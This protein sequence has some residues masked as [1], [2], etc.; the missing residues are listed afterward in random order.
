MATVQAATNSGATT[1]RITV[2]K[3]WA[4]DSEAVR[5]E[6]TEIHLKKVSATLKTGLEVAIAMK[7]LAGNSGASDYASPNTTIYAFKKAEK[8]KYDEAVAR[9]A[10][11]ENVAESGL[12]VYMWFDNGTIYYYSEADNIYMNSNSAH[13]FRGMRNLADIDGVSAL[14][15][16]YVEV[17]GGMFANDTSLVN[18]SPLANWDTGNVKGM[19]YMFGT[20]RSGSD[21]DDEKNYMSYTDLSPLANWNTQSV[22]DMFCIF[23]NARRITTLAPIGG[24]NVSN[25]V[26]AEQMFNRTT[27]LE[28]ASAIE[29]WDLRRVGNEYQKMG[30]SP[31]MDGE[32]EV[33]RFLGMFRLSGV[34]ENGNLPN[35]TSRSGTW[36]SDGALTPDD[37]PLAGSVPVVTKT[38]DAVEEFTIGGSGVKWAKNGDTWM[39][40]V[41][42]SN[43]GSIWRAWEKTENGLVSAKGGKGAYVESSAGREGYGKDE[44][45]AVKVSSGAVEFVNTYSAKAATVVKN[46]KTA[47]ENYATVFM[48]IGGAVAGLGAMIGVRRRV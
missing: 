8:A 25:L 43:D 12:A 31:T 34:L 19:R 37:A 22:V 10:T 11:M 36:D 27:S 9:G 39:A 32:I 3:K 17:M 47:G 35:F 5:S 4:G 18:L 28:D 45:N 23:K 44:A 29:G 26:M 48:V 14:N 16:T 40:S 33:G 30:S 41:E 21:L 20:V 24:W 38:K 46:P 6:D 15:T 1:R 13:M 42:V 2:T 7:T